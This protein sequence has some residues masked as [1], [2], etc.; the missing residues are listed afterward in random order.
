MS[1]LTKDPKSIQI[2]IQDITVPM[3]PSR[4]QMYR[5]ANPE[6]TPLRQNKS[7]IYR[8]ADKEE[9]IISPFQKDQFLNEYDNSHIQ[10][11]LY[12][13]GDINYG[14]GSTRQY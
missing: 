14:R 4:I 2:R 5:P 1:R 7:D 6:I 9:N 3:T 13:A 8:H 11:R 10:R 12:G